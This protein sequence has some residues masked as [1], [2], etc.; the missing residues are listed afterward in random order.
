[1]KSGHRRAWAPGGWLPSR[2]NAPPEKLIRKENEVVLKHG[3]SLFLQELQKICVCDPEEFNRLQVFGEVFEDIC[4]SSLIF[5]DI[6]KEIKVIE[7]R[8]SQVTAESCAWVLHTWAQATQKSCRVSWCPFYKGGESFM[9]SQRNTR[10]ATW[11]LSGP[12]E[13]NTQ[14]AHFWSP[15]FSTK[16]S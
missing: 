15:Y 12:C 2:Q 8:I 5:G 11:V 1:M 13:K 7:T 4:K 16:A 3:G 14:L 6:L 9:E 10:A